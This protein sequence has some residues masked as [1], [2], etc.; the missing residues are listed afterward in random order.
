MKLPRD[1]D[2]ETRD[3]L[4]R[5]F[6]VDANLRITISDI[7]QSLFFKDI[8]WERLRMHD[9][10]QDKIP[11]VPESDEHSALLYRATD[12]PEVS[13]NSKANRPVTRPVTRPA[14]TTAGV[15]VESEQSPLL[16]KSSR[17]PLGDFTLIKVNK[18]F[19]NF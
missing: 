17:V 15:T 10:E 13:N 3:L 2:H 4:N 5:I 14:G 11:C 19:E 9:I 12:F 16:P 8:N 7:M 1:I 6:T 18:A